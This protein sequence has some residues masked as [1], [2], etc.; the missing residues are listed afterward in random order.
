MDHLDLAKNNAN[1]QTTEQEKVSPL[2]L[3]RESGP[4]KEIENNGYYIINGQNSTVEIKS[5]EII[6]KDD[7]ISRHINIQNLYEVKLYK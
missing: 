2:Q 5:E 7:I 4:Q 1:K 6:S 3:I